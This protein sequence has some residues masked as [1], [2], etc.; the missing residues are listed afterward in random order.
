MHC[1][2]HTS[3]SAMKLFLYRSRNWNVDSTLIPGRKRTEKMACFHNYLLLPSPEKSRNLLFYPKKPTR[4]IFFTRKIPKP[5]LRCF[6]SISFSP[7]KYGPIFT[8]L[9]QELSPSPLTSLT[10]D[11]KPHPY[12][13]SPASPTLLPPHLL[14]AASPFH[15]ISFSPSKYRSKSSCWN[16]TCCTVLKDIFCRRNFIS[17]SPRS[18]KE[19]V[20]VEVRGDNM[21]SWA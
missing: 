17:A 3:V 6:H 8:L 20:S 19:S 2:S 10:K 7:S 11:E 14:S 9:P 4:T 12:P 21:S 18:E 13:V 15:S 5:T 16:M 1:H